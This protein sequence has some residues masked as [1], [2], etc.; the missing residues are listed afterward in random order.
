MQ[1]T[2]LQEGYQR[3]VGLA[4]RA[5]L[6][7]EARLAAEKNLGEML[8]SKLASITADAIQVRDLTLQRIIC[9]NMMIGPVVWSS[10]LEFDLSCRTLFHLAP[11]A[12][13]R[14]GRGS[15]ISRQSKSR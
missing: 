3:D 7:L 14:R 5:V 9:M 10:Y 1:N 8:E 12:L 15:R 2:K 4:R 6:N 13:I 11:H